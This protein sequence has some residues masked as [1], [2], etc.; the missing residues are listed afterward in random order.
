MALICALSRAI[1]AACSSAILALIACAP[2]RPRLNPADHACMQ[3]LVDYGA[4]F[5]QAVWG[6]QG[7]ALWLGRPAASETE[8][9]NM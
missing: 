7:C 9:P 8:A 1:S 4:D 5:W 6:P 2:P 3:F